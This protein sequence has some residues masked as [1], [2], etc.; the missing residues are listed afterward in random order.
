MNKPYLICKW[1]SDEQGL[2]CIWIRVG[3]PAKY[4]LSVST[5]GL[6]PIY[7]KAS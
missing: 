4:S 7:K 1:I 3:E 2:H 5:S 6:Q